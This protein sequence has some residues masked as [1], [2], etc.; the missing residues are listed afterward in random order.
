M[1]IFMFTPYRR[2]RINGA[3]VSM[4]SSIKVDHGFKL[5]SG[6]TEDL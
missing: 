6:Q 3:M 2:N 5:G 4:F 1:D